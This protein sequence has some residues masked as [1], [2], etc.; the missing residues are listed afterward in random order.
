MSDVVQHQFG[1]KRLL[2]SP[3][4]PK[5]MKTHTAEEEEEPLKIN[6]FAFCGNW[7]QNA[8]FD[9]FLINCCIN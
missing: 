2:Y 1:T 8:E 6:T 7:S 9:L 4:G 3:C 5:G